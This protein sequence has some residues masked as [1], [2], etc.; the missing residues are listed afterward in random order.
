MVRVRVLR[1]SDEWCAWGDLGVWV[2]GGDIGAI[3]VTVLAVL[4]VL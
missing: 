3:R 4:V 1:I 2:L